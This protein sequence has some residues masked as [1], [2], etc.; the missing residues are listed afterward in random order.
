M[1]QR[2]ELPTQPATMR[3]E[4]WFESGLISTSFPLPR[5]TL[6]EG[7]VGAGTSITSSSKTEQDGMY[8]V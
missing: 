1:Q 7:P 8:Q 2:T 4:K 5:F 3:G 6:E